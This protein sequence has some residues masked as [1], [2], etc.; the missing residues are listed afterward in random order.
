MHG[1][2]VVGRHHLDRVPRA[3]IEKRAIRTFARTLLTA[4]AEIRVDF[5]PPEWRM[6]FVRHPEHAGFNRTILD[7]RRRTGASG[8]AIGGNRE[9]ARPLFTGSFAVALRHW[10]V[11]VY[12]VVHW[13]DSNIALRNS[14]TICVGDALC[15]LR[16][17]SSFKEV[18]DSKGR[19][20]R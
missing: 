16:N 8:T 4:N 18:V 3:A 11:L 1:F 13:S 14:S 15:L 19:N 2:P 10:P 7:T 12:D 9:D 20:I 5:D 6:V 17:V